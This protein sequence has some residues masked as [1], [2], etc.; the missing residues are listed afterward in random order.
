MNPQALGFFRQH[1]LPGR[2]CLVG[3]ADLIYMAIREGQR[4][5]TTDG[6][7]SKWNHTFIMG[8]TRDDGRTDGSIYILESDLQVSVQ[9]WQVKNGAMESRL[10]KWC[11]DD[12]EHA[13]VLGIDLSSSEKSSIV[14]KGLEL[15]Y[16]ENHL[17]YPV[18][19]LF[20]TFWA[21]ITG[22]LS[23]KN[24]FDLDYAVQCSTLVGMCY[25]SI[26]KDI[27]VSSI[28]PTN[29]TPELIYQSPIFTF[30]EEWHL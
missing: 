17:R 23:Q 27:V 8:S 11:R 4:K 25:K 21:I 1:Y 10:V 15:A 9:E 26:G 12:I 20:G 7:P 6:K 29:L 19:E 5:L 30:R 3:C 16:D 18:G 24:I 28:D 14:R 2:I 22:R 13:A